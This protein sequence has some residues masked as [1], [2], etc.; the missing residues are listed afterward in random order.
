ML[1][2]MYRIP[3]EEFPPLVQKAAIGPKKKMIFMHDNAPSH[4][5]RYTCDAMSKFG[6]SDGRVMLWP[7]CSPDLNPIENFWSQLKSKVYEGGR[8]F[9][10]KKDLWEQIQ[11][12]AA[13][14]NK[15][16]IKQ[17]SN[18]MDSRLLRVVLR[19]GVIFIIKI[20]NPSKTG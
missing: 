17:L 20:L 6:F 12:S 11:T 13:G 19:K 18:S 5:A 9:S 3:H 1:N 8:Q 10:S 2:R 7:A 16:S 4:A 15:D 14:I